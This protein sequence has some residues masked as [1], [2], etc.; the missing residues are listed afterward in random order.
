LVKSHASRKHPAP[1]TIS[2]AAPGDI[3]TARTER[4]YRMFAACQ[5]RR[6][7]RTPQLSTLLPAAFALGIAG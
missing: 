1:S 4:S 7:W 3:D 5:P 6:L 2:P